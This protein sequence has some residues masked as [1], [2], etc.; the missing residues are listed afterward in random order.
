VQAAQW[1]DGPL[2]RGWLGGL[3]LRGKTILAIKGRR[4]SSCGFIE[5]YA[6]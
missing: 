3:K 1:V 6:S 2:K 4:C 5:L